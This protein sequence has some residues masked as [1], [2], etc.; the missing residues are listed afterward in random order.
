[1]LEP[2]DVTPPDRVPVRRALLS[3]SNKVGLVDLASALH[4]HG[5]ELVSTGGT[6]RKIAEAGLPVRPVEELTGFPEMMDGRV[7]TLHP[8][9]FAGILGVRDAAAHATAA[10]EHEIGWVD[11]VC[12]NLYP[13]EETTDRPD[14][15]LGEA[16]ENVDIGGPSL[17]RAAAKNHAY[18]TVLTDPG[19]Y[20]AVLEEVRASGDGSVGLRTRRR[21]A[22]EAFAAT[23]RY[24]AAISGF[25]QSRRE[26]GGGPDAP[27]PDVSS[28]GYAKV[29][30]LRYGE[31]P[32]Q[33][34]AYYRRAGAG[35]HLLGGV[36]QLHG[37]ELSF[38]NLLDLDSARAI[39][40]D[41][42]EEPGCVIV[43]HNNPCGAAIGATLAEAYTKAFACDPV[44]AF[45]GIIVATRTVDRP[46]AEAIAQQFVE[47]LF[48]PG[49]DA[50][51]LEVLR[52]KP[53]VRL[54]QG[55]EPDVRDRPGGNQE[56][57]PVLGGLLV[58]D[59]DTVI[60]DRATMTVP[61]VA[62]PDEA[63]WRDVLFA[64]RVMRHV[65]SNA[66]VYS[67]DGATLGIGAGQMSRVDS[68]RLAVQKAAEHGLDLAG[69]AMASDAFFPF[70]DGLQVGLDAGARAVIQPG[71][72]VRDDAVVAA[73]DAVGATMVFTGRRH[74][75]H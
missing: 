1:M 14:V 63:Q 66:I 21:L 46:A 13:F 19:Q 61:T 39:A 70:P 17:I 9:L 48:A 71:G 15:T 34:G 28:R 73:A 5:S 36:R 50:E 6:A 20:G 41:L 27:F 53:N 33:R 45:G 47:V 23:G 37:K 25:L 10:A 3:V 7:K 52:E 2:I 26:F 44:S 32:H 75:R 57:R 51:A 4:E 42:G 64:W 30:D 16:V 38:N 65:K 22:A 69:A 18:A 68:A 40:R 49:F 55:G 11:L 43:K 12:V 8:N 58:Q 31:N 74:F 72:S 29:A 56:V 67:R 54:L 59:A 62:Q 24:D 35:T 60:V